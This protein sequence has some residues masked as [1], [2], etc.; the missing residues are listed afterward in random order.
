[1][2][3]DGAARPRL[4]PPYVEFSNGDVIAG[5][6]SGCRLQASEFGDRA[7][8][9]IATESP[10][11]TYGNGV[12]AVRA[13]CVSRIV[14]TANPLAQPGGP[15]VLLTD[16][17]LLTTTSLRFTE[18]GLTLL[19]AAG[20]ESVNF[21]QIADLTLAVDRTRALLEDCLFADSVRSARLV[22][23]TTRDGTALT[24]TRIHQLLVQDRRLRESAAGG[25]RPTELVLQP[26]WALE[27]VTV[28]N[29]SVCQS[30]FR[31][32]NEIP[33]SLL[34]AVTLAERSTIGG[35]RPWQRNTSVHRAP[36][37][38]G[39][40][41]ADTGIGMHAHCEVA[42]DLPDSAREL[43]LWVG[44][45]QRVAP[46]GCVVCKIRRDDTAG[47]VLWESGFIRGND[48]PKQVGPL[49]VR[50]LRRLVLVAEMGHQGRP[51]DAD[52]L[53]IR[54]DVVWLAPLVTIDPHALRTHDALADI[55]PG[56]RA[57][58][59]PP[60]QLQEVEL[61]HQWNAFRV[62]WDP[63]LRIAK[64][65]ELVLTQH[66]AITSA[67][68]VLEFNTALPSHLEDH[69]FRLT[70]NGEPLAWSASQDRERMLKMR[71]VRLSSRPSTSARKRDDIPNEDLAYRWDLQAYR[72]QTVVIELRLKAGETFSDLAWNS[73]AL[74]S[75][76][77]DSG[78]VVE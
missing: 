64:G 42:F 26:S 19:T 48:P 70:V 47:E 10:L 6:V 44:I 49:N 23:L 31:L 46:G 66:V 33:L 50:G 11:N 74:R 52:P 1:M 67:N 69:D 38:A 21:S 78:A 61:T 77:A 63:L 7:V 34:P 56:L 36:L 14:T 41:E 18:T 4:R 17:R 9:L 37:T 35:T 12:L 68:D 43:S 75:A 3:R 28:P 55:L 54:D 65:H 16:G 57:W 53:D 62:R 73:L 25:A 20:I 27:P 5:T 59:V 60:E 71:T 32:P 22:R 13:D 40:M 30:S 2:Y 51:Q 76:T 29:A 72:G 45:D 39:E 8:L 58:Q 15:R 24:S